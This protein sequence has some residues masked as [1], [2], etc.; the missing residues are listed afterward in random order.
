MA[1]LEKMTLLGDGE[2]AYGVNA[3]YDEL[4]TSIDLRSP[5][6]RAVRRNAE[7]L[8][9]K[10]RDLRVAAYF[11]LAG[12]ALE[13]LEGFAAGVALVRWLVLE[14]WEGFYPRLDPDDGNDP[15]ERIN[16][17]AMISPA[18]DA[19]DDP[20]KFVQLFR[21]QRLAPQGPKYTLRDLLMA[22]GELDAGDEKVEPALLTAEFTATPLETIAARAATVEAIAADLSAIADAVSDKTGGRYTVSFT[23]LQGELK[24][25]RRFYA[26][27]N[28][29]VDGDA[30][31][32]GTPALPAGDKDSN[33]TTAN[34]AAVSSKPPCQGEP[35]G[36]AEA[37]ALLKKGC[38]YFKKHEPT[39]PVP[40]LVERALRMADMNFLDL[41]TEIDPSGVDRGRDILGVKG[42]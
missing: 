26:R 14:H 32:G 12:L 38:D 40:Y 1:M 7:A 41:L 33:R 42:E 37:L 36:R 16:I 24:T 3:E 34:D 27:F 17:L 11:A 25:L 8:W 4:L 30:V 13:G 9:L 5:D 23:T 18:P 2:S 21:A 28:H 29:G 20:V 15:T 10:T 31:D 35:N 22:E 19:Y 6:W 39:S